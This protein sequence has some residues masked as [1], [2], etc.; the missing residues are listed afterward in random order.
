M[1]DGLTRRRKITVSDK[2]AVVVAENSLDQLLEQVDAYITF[3]DKAIVEPP[4][5][6]ELAATNHLIK[7]EDKLA[8]L[9]MLVTAIMENK[10]I[11]REIDAKSCGDGVL[12][13]ALYELDM[14]FD[15]EEGTEQIYGKKLGKSNRESR[16]I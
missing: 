14:A 9:K 2:W 1:T 10:D 7:L 13:R 15:V 12:A 4:N 11:A 5:G 8:I 6:F 16:I 3:Y